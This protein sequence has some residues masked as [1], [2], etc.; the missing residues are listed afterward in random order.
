MPCVVFY[1]V[2]LASQNIIISCCRD[3]NSLY[4]ARSNGMKSGTES[5][6]ALGRPGG[7]GGAAVRVVRRPESF[8]VSP[9]FQG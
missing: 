8:A 9:V 3:R 7:P 2:V 5:G 1:G 4:S 6:R